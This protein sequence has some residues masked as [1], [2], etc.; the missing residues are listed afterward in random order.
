MVAKEKRT[1]PGWIDVKAALL[2]FDRVGLLC[3]LQARKTKHF[4]MR[5]WIWVLTSSSLT[6]Q[7]FQGGYAL[8]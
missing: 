2:A 6:N 1:S 7:K 5:A 3:T 4:C 8:T